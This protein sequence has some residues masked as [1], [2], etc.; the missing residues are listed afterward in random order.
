MSQPKE[1]LRRL[2]NQKAAV[3]ARC[4][5][6][7][8]ALR[9]IIEA[10]GPSN[11]TMLNLNEMETIQTILFSAMTMRVWP[12]VS[13]DAK[14]NRL[15]IEITK[16]WTVSELFNAFDDVSDAAYKATKHKE[17]AAEKIQGI[18]DET[19]ESFYNVRERLREEAYGGKPPHGFLSWGDYFKSL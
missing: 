3:R 8:D 12:A 4:L 5:S 15:G 7:L 16:P 10:A 9:S 6:Y 1:R 11:G 19:G 13:I 18:M 2:R 14:A 17:P